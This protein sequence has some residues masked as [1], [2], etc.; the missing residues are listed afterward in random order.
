MAADAGAEP[1]LER[2]MTLRAAKASTVSYGTST[3]GPFRA[4]SRGAC[5]VITF[6]SA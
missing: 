4:P 3:S 5:A 2:Q 6:G 1:R